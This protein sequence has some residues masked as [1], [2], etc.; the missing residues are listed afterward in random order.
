MLNRQTEDHQDE[1]TSRV[2]NILLIANDDTEAILKA[3][4]I[5]G[6]FVTSNGIQIIKIEELESS[7]GQSKLYIGTDG[8]FKKIENGGS[9]EAL[10]SGGSAAYIEID[11]STETTY[12][13]STDDVEAGIRIVVINDSNAVTISLPQLST[14]NVTK[15]G[16]VEVIVGGYNS[17][18]ME[19]YSGDYIALGAT[20]SSTA[21]ELDSTLGFDAV[22]LV[23]DITDGVWVV[24][25]GNNI[26]MFSWSGGK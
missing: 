20:K 15:G 7:D 14:L 12:S 11:S 26:D 8:T 1:R 9:E 2:T 19:Q 22:R 3:L 21:L 6:S 18:T 13:V 5:P 17:V 4:Q 24:M 25:G 10:G 23:Y 16:Y